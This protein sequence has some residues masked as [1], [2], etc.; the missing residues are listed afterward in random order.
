MK[1]W[2]IDTR[3]INFFFFFVT[4]V[5]IY[6]SMRMSIKKKEWKKREMCYRAR[7]LLSIL[8]PSCTS[9]ALFCCRQRRHDR[10]E[11]GESRRN[12]YLWSLSTLSFPLILTLYTH[13]LLNPER[14]SFQHREKYHIFLTNSLPTSPSVLFLL[15]LLLS[16]LILFYCKKNIRGGLPPS[17]FDTLHFFL[18]LIQQIFFFF[19]I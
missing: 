9:S 10:T 17:T 7:A 16:R 2:M 1:I 5:R 14:Q 12:Q 15:L 11:R 8:W 19:S 3:S 18:F 4:P 6:N 13:T